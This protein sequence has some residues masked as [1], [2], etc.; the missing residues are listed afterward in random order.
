M[1]EVAHSPPLSKKTT[2][3]GTCRKV[4]PLIPSLKIPPLSPSCST[5]PSCK[6]P[7]ASSTRN[8]I[9][10]KFSGYSKTMVQRYARHMLKKNDIDFVNCLTVV[11]TSNL[12]SAN[13]IHPSESGRAADHDMHLKRM[14]EATEYLQS[15]IHKM[16]KDEEKFASIDYLSG[17]NPKDCPEMYQR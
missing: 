4:P 8:R 5:G 13:S 12:P 17:Y 14:T 1:L 15:C 16:R 10:Q 9:S 3:P 2:Q 7:V 6:R 11:V